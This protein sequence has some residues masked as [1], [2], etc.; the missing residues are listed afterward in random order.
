MELRYCEECGDVTRIE[1]GGPILSD[2]YVCER[3][4]NGG[5]DSGKKDGAS[6]DEASFDNFLQEQPLNL[7]SDQTIALRR[8]PKP[9]DSQRGQPKPSDEPQKP[10]SNR[11]RLVK[12]ATTGTVRTTST[13]QPATQDGNAGSST[14]AKSAQRL[15]FRCIHCRAT[16]S[17][18]PVNRTSKL[19]CPECRQA[20]YVT[21]SG[22]LLKDTASAVISKGGSTAF[23]T[24]G[25]VV[26]KKQGSSFRRKQAATLPRPGSSVVKKADSQAVRKP[27]GPV[28]K[29]GSSVRKSAVRP[30]SSRDLQASKPGSVRLTKMNPKTAAPVG[31]ASPQKPTSAFQEHQEL[32]DPS[33][34]AFITETPTMN[35][36]ELASGEAMRIIEQEF[37]EESHEMA[38]PPESSPLED[39]PD[40]SEILEEGDDAASV[41]ARHIDAGV[42]KIAASKS[43]AGKQSLAARMLKALFT[44]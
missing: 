27:G 17:I 20:I 11:L 2:H 41:A 15:L 23:A 42:K 33:K 14:P 32:Q 22:S 28:P 19:L 38:P 40:E 26:V 1:S 35:L 5:P 21:S 6:A 36:Q 43:K 31:A 13:A 34:T 44:P 12:T 16:L 29:Q 24:A 10:K 4:E 25:S 8:K 18:R 30:P 9:S 3:C 7:F 37:K 39:L